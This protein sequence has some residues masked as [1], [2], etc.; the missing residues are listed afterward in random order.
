[1]ADS[2]NKNPVEPE[3]RLDSL[4]DD[5][6]ETFCTSTTTTKPDFI[7]Q[8]MEEST[9]RFEIPYKDGHANKDDFQRHVEILRVLIKW[10]DDTKICLVDNRNHRVKNLKGEKWMDHDYYKSRFNIHH[11]E[12]Q[13]KTVIAHRIRSKKSLTMIKG[14][15]TVIT[16]LKKTKTFL[17]TCRSGRPKTNPNWEMGEMTKSSKF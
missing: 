8:E 9:V 5:D 3:N 16:F 15:S 14:D 6:E 12:T 7:E 11:E 10:F 4:I 2:S 17:Q 13:R 1:M